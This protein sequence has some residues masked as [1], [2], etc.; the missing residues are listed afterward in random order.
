MS[1]QQDSDA[2][3]RVAVV[4][5]GHWGRNLVRDF[6]GLGALAGIVEANP[7]TREALIA[8]HGTRGL[9]YDEA[10]ADP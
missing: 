2:T 6:A 8:Q 1:T 3:P 7:A 4:G 9:S 5:C 10:L